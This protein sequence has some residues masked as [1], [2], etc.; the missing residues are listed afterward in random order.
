[1]KFPDVKEGLKKFAKSVFAQVAN[2]L[3]WWLTA[4][5]GSVFVTAFLGEQLY[6]PRILLS[7]LVAFMMPLVF[8]AA[9][10]SLVAK[11]SNGVN[12]ALLAG[13]TTFDVLAGF[14]S[15]FWQIPGWKSALVVL[16]F[17]IGGFFYTMWLMTFATRL[18][19]D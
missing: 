6:W 3:K 14:F 18:E 12:A 7:F 5:G 13:L 4:A 11:R 1:M 16:V 8:F 2:R 10:R 15:V 17:A 19:T 9:I